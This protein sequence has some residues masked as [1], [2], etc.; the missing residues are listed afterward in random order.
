MLVSKA[1]L[2]GFAVVTG[3][4]LMD[5]YANG[6]LIGTASKMAPFS[7]LFRCVVIGAVMVIWIW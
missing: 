5:P 3:V 2:P 7:W 4:S 6:L 1:L